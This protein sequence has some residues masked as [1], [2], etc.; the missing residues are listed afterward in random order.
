MRSQTQGA[1]V[2]DAFITRLRS[3]GRRHC[4]WLGLATASPVLLVG[5]SA[6]WDGF[7]R[8]HLN[9]GLRSLSNPGV[10]GLAYERVAIQSGNRTLDGYLVA[11]AAQCTGPET[12]MLIF[13][14]R[15]ETAPDWFPVQ[16]LLHDRCVASLVFDYSGH[17]HSTP[18][19]TISHL[20]QDAH[21]AAEFFAARFG[22]SPRRC[23]LG[24]SMG[25]ALALQVANPAAVS[26]DCV[27]VVAPFSS[28]KA[29][30]QRS[31]VARVL[32]F[33]FS[34]E[35]NNVEQVA[36]LNKSLLW[37]HS[38]DDATVPLAFGQAVYQAKT[39]R[40][41]AQLVQGFDHNAIHRQRPPQLWEPI[42]RFAR[43]G[44]P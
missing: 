43:H 27:V 44:T 10:V 30:A 18:D 31:G 12:A 32:T 6:A 35:W 41:F 33:W 20:N 19:G 39:G 42:I 8:D 16:R 23:V 21:A 22:A 40:K 37:V 1:I 11:H 4:L 7:A 14:G 9:P 29:M 13:H 26:S 15:D 24:F 36:T 3:I 5:C 17:G 25:A 28:L 34:D 2:Y 38:E